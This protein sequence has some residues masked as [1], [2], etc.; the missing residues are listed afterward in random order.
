M[1]GV[2]LIPVDALP[3]R[4]LTEG[5]AV[6][7]VPWVGAG[8]AQRA[9]CE[10]LVAGVADVVVGLIHLLGALERVAGRAKVSAETADVHL[11]HIDRGLAF[12]YPFGHH[13]ADAARA[14][15]TVGAEA[16]GYEEAAHV[17]LAEAELVVGRKRLRPVDQLGDGDLIHHRHAL[18]RANSNLLKARPVLFE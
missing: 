17:A 2:G 16:S 3:A 1:D 11:P 5:G 10:A 18:A 15:E 9:S 4:L 12:E 13:F 7:G 14:G 8:G 6:L